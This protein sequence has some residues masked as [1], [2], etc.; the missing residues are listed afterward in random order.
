MRSTYS[1]AHEPI[2]RR[3]AAVRLSAAVPCDA[4]RRVRTSRITN[5][6]PSRTTRSVSPGGT[7]TFLSIISQFWVRANSAAI[8]SPRNAVRRRSVNHEGCSASRGTGAIIPWQ[9]SCQ[10]P[11]THVAFHKKSSSTVRRNGPR[12]ST[13]GARSPPIQSFRPT[14]Y[15][16]G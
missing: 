16:I 15:F 3:F 6:A 4:D 5:I 10:S 12:S 1:N 7:P 9:M 11:G 8:V 14:K 13:G 2:L